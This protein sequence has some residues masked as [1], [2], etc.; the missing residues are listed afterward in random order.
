MARGGFGS[1]FDGPI[2]RLNPEQLRAVTAGDGPQLILAGAGSG[3][4]RTIVHRIGHLIAERGVAPHRILAVTFTNK[5]A[6]ELSQRLE[7]LIGD[8]AG[9]VVAGT[10]HA[11]SLRFL[12][13]F[14]ELLGYGRDARVLDGADR[15]QLL[16]RMLR[17]GGIPPD[18]LHPS[19]LGWWIDQCKN[20]GEVWAE[21]RP[22]QVNGVD[23]RALY[24]AYQ[25]E[26]IR[27]DRMDFGDLLLNCVLLL[28]HHEQ[29]AA[30]MR[31]RFD[32]VLVD[33]YQ[34]TNPVQHEWLLRLCRDHRNLTVVGDD[35]Q[36]IYGWRGADVGHILSFARHWPGAGVHR[37]ERNYRSTAAV[38]ALANAVI[39]GSAERHEKRLRPVRGAG[40]TPQLLDCSGDREEAAAVAAMLRRRR[41]EGV[42]WSEMAVLYRV[43][44]QAQLFERAFR[45]AGIPCRIVGGVGFFERKEVKDAL[46]YWALLHRCADSLQLRRILNTPR[47]GIGEK[48]GAVVLEA[49]RASGLRPA[50]WLDLLA[51]RPEGLP[52]PCR[53]LAPLAALLVRLR[54]QA[55]GMKDGGL[56][57]LLEESGYLASLRALGEVEYGTREELLRSLSAAVVDALGAGMDPAAFLDDAALMQSGEEPV[58]EGE[59]AVS[60][61][62]L[63]RAKGLEFDTVCIAGVEEGL[64]PHQRA[65]DEGGAAL[66]EERRLLYVGITRAK[67]RLLLSR[68]RRRRLFR[69]ELHPR[70]SRFLTALPEGR[71]Q[72][73]PEEELLGAPA[74]EGAAG[75]PIGV[76]MQV[77]HPSFGEGVV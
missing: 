24:R 9:G 31:A 36:S 37:L 34:D 33:E 69:D 57:A 13:R 40:V 68:A 17:A 54:T 5:S 18:R 56:W 46:A 61:M 48:G 59:D 4:T 70:L 26:L 66:E 73:V 29:A 67:N 42:A 25:E 28:R 1:R 71:L 20:R 74:V 58:G 39:A 10:F 51:D 47:R 77:R 76:G 23:L 3:K 2:V 6:R 63:H 49:L 72:R 62:S 45:M 60:L 22:E 44:R 43:H 15:Q 41:A 30:W 8:G 52:A 75:S 32:H 16:T 11:V 50:E 12:R 53:R 21:A 14:G 27:I 38:L 19:F 55:E 65:V 7:G 64:L 35:D